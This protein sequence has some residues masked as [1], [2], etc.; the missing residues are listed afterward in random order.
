MTTTTTTTTTTA[1]NGETTIQKV[2]QEAEDWF[3]QEGDKLHHVLGNWLD[4]L[5]TLT[6]SGAWISFAY[7]AWAF[8]RH[9][10]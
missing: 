10:V 2:E 1:P 4:H 7:A 8:A 5:H 6:R 3:N 9:L